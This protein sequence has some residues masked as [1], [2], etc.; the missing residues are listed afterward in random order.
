[1]ITEAALT[2]ALTAT[3]RCSACARMGFS[4]APTGKHAR[5]LTSARLM[6]P[7]V[8]RCVSTPRAHITAAVRTGSGGLRPQESAR[9]LTSVRR[10]AVSVPMGVSTPRAEC[11]AAAPRGWS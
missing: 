3:T 4:W 1:M 8:T 11:S 10:T 2:S 7:S 9:I 6:T 5:M